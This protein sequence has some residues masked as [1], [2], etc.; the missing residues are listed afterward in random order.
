[1][2]A[3]QPGDLLPTEYDFSKAPKLSVPGDWN[4]QLDS[5]FFY[6]GARWYERDFEFHPKEH[7]RFSFMSAQQI[8]LRGSGSMAERCASTRADTQVSIAMSPPR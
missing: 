4:T 3:A 5:L 1:M 7:T 6:E 2:Q 8:S